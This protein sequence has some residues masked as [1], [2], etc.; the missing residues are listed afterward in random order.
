MELPEGELQ[1]LAKD[2]EDPT[3]Q[4]NLLVSDAKE[5]R[6]PEEMQ[7]HLT[8]SKDVRFCYKIVANNVIMKFPVTIKESF[9]VEQDEAKFGFMIEV[10]QGQGEGFK[11]PIQFNTGK[12][13]FNTSGSNISSAASQASYKKTDH[14]GKLRA[15]K[16]EMQDASFVSDASGKEK[17]DQSF[18]SEQT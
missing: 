17:V 10:K 7:E 5:K 2:E 15:G 4:G 9:N 1:I 3:A 12:L 8:N 6:S 18:R 16:A 11:V 13:K 14:E